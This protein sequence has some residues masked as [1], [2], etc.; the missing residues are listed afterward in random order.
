MD[1][2]PLHVRTEIL[3]PVYDAQ[4][5]PIECKDCVKIKIRLRKEK[6][7][8]LNMLYWKKPVFL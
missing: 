7:D 5:I 3:L 8:K 6:S 4:R 1:I 2:S